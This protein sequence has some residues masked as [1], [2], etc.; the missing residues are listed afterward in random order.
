MRFDASMES[1]INTGRSES[2]VDLNETDLALSRSVL[3]QGR[4]MFISFQGKFEC[5]FFLCLGC[6]G[7][8]SRRS[9]WLATFLRILTIISVYLLVNHTQV[10]VTV[11]IRA[12]TMNQWV[13][14]R[15][16]MESVSSWNPQFTFSINHGVFFN[17]TIFC[18]VFLF[19]QFNWMVKKTCI[20]LC[21]NIVFFL[22]R[23]ICICHLRV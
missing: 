8:S 2:F 20:F 15:N 5:H 12:W 22:I 7:I 19:C 18:L 9:N 21:L 6:R 13:V 14:Q 3:N 1:L 11:G 10:M 4:D 23:S 16:N 17:S